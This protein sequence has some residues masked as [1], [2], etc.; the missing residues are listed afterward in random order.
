[1]FFCSFIFIFKLFLFVCF[2]TFVSFHFFLFF[3]LSLFNKKREVLCIR[4]K[5][6][7]L[8]S[9]ATLT[10]QSFRVCK[11]NLAILKVAMNNFCKSS[12]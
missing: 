4:V 11:D 1:M 3:L 7:A 2:F 5:G 6:N 10:N 12:N 8:R 9:V